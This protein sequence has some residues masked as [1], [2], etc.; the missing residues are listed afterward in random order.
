MFNI[1]PILAILTN[2][3][4]PPYDRNGNV[5]PVNKKGGKK[6]NGHNKKVGKRSE[7]KY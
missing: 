5:T 1:I 3:L 2:K 6:Y 4:L 7:K